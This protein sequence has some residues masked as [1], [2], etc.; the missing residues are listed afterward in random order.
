M[1]QSNVQRRSVLVVGAGPIGL[2]AA[3]AL[4]HF[5]L[6]ATILEAESK[7]RLRPG[8]RA[9]YFHKATLQHLEDIF[10]R[11]GKT[12]AE[13]G[14]VWPIKRALFRGKEVYMKRYP[15]PD[16]NELP[17][18]TSLPQVE[19]EKFLYQAC[20]ESGVEFVWETPVAEVKTDERGVVVITQ[21]GERWTCDYLIA[22]DGAR[23]TVRQSVGI[24]MEGPRT[25]DY[26]VV[27]D[28]KE[29]END[30]LPLERVFHYQHPAVEG[31]NVLFVPFA[32]G[33]RIDLQLL[34]GDDPEQLGSVEGV[35]QWLPKVMPEKYA[36]RITWVSTYRFF[37]VVAK[38]LTDQHHRLL[39]AGEAAHLFA[40]FGARGMN[41]GVPDAIMAAKAIQ[42]ALNAKTQEEAKTAIAAAAN[43]RLIAARYNRDCAGIAL[44]HIQGTDPVI[45]IKRE[46][47]ASLAPILPR[48][49]KWLDEGPYGPK[50][51][52][53]QL[54]TKY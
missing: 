27:V 42:A 17:P 41:S 8:S 2:T 23:S 16:P 52:P 35:K 13:H 44:E 34:N 38:S 45:N 26:F 21:S 36:G 39:L 7:D 43:E 28:V 9:I 18:F 49:G 10:P 1:N 24:E 53:P 30:P 25:K 14:V 33:W 19:A 6:P 22:A 51:G 29:D 47:A 32:G 50:S 11:L 31:R 12:F 20:L 46:V 4:R 40:P 3:L 48:F 54:S 5:G 15:A 37:Q